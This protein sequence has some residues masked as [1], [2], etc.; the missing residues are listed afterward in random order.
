[1]I[2]PAS[3]ATG[4]ES[5]RRGRSMGTLYSAMTRPGRIIENYPVPIERPRRIDSAPVAELASTITDQLRAEVG[6]HG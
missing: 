4:A 1:M 6:R 3:S 2:V 5:I